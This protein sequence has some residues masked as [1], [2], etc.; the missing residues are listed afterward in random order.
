[1]MILVRS[2]KTQNERENNFELFLFLTTNQQNT[3]LS[4]LLARF[5]SFFIANIP[6]IGAA[7]LW[8]LQGA[9]GAEADLPACHIPYGTQTDSPTNKS[10]F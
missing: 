6:T 8:L 9:A 5:Y 3:R 1:M 7:I 2:V 4:P 10:R